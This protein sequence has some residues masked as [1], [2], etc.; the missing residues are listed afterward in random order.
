M[1]DREEYGESDWRRMEQQHHPGVPLGVSMGRSDVRS[2][3]G[4]SLATDELEKTL[5]LGFQCDASM[6]HGHRR[7]HRHHR[8]LSIRLCRDATVHLF[9][10]L[11]L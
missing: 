8:Y 6:A 11:N 3:D 4:Y 5:S 1:G 9:S 7:L 2:R 10:I